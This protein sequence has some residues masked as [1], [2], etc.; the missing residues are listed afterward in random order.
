MIRRVALLLAVLVLG[1]GLA[2]APSHLIS[3]PASS[4]DFVHFES[5]HVHPAVMTPDGTRLLVVSTP[6]NRLSVFDLTGAKPQ[7]IAEIPVGLEPVSVAVRDNGEAWVVNTLSDDISVVDLTTLHVKAT[8]HVGDEPS[9][10]LFAG[11]SGRAFVS[12]TQEDLI[13]I[14]DPTT[15]AEIGAIPVAGRMPRSLAK[16]A[17]GTLVFAAIFNSGNRTTVVQAAEVQD[18]VPDDP[19]FPRDTMNKHGHVLAPVVSHIVQYLDFGVDGAGFYDEYG[20]LWKSKTGYTMPD[21]DVVEIDASTQAVTRNFRGT[22]SVNYN[23]NVLP[24]GRLVTVSTEARNQLRFEP[25][26][27]GYMVDTR[28]SYINTGGVL[29]SRLLN[30][31]INY[32]VTPGPQSEV[33]S[34]M[35]IPTSVAFSASGT[36]AYVTSFSNDKVGIL[37]PNAG[38]NQVLARIPTVAGPSMVVPDEARGVMYIVGR[39]HN[40][41]QTISTDSLVSLDVTR[42][43]FD[44]TPDEIVNGRKFFYG[45]KT[46]GHGDQA[47]ATCHTFGDMDNMVWDLG[48]PFSE[49]IDPP[50]VNPQGLAGFDPQKGP[51]ATQSLRGMLNTEPLHWRGDRTDITAFNHA[52]ISLMGRT[53]QLPDSEMTAFAEFSMPLVYPPNPFRNLDNTLP[54][55][56]DR[57]NPSAGEALFLSGSLVASG[58]NCVDCHNLPAGT[59]RMMV[60]LDTLAV[61]QDLKVPQLRNLYKKTG[62]TDEVGAMTKRGFGY[63]H[64]GGIDKLFRFLGSPRFAFDP[65]TAIGNVARRDVEAF[66]LAFPT[67]MHPAVGVQVTFD[68][69]SNPAGEA[70]VDTMRALV[71]ASQIDLIAKGRVGTQP[72]G[73]QYLGG[74]AWKSDK[75]AE[76]NL[77]TAGL[78]ALAL[79]PSSALTVTGVP[80]GNGLRM[81]I[82]RDRDTYLDGDE[83]DAGSDTGS[84]LST[85]LTVSVNGGPDALRTALERVSPNPS[86]AQAQ[87]RF[88]LA[89]AGHVDLSVYDVLGR[90]VRTLARGRA[91]EAGRWNLSW[92]GRRN[93]GGTAGAGVYF[94][95]M[96]TAQGASTLPIVRIR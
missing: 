91:F 40:E 96:R 92:D 49:Y 43:G 17:A 65:D 6:D 50:V 57:P 8:I 68:G 95:R 21:V 41:L 11:P 18:S 28:I 74:D 13:K 38:A 27:R 7:R 52:F 12:V 29:S 48:D 77:T 35:G 15:R 45:G 20:K 62:Y 46:S 88:A 14:Y 3:S 69:G 79:D 39:F 51:M 34:A 32:S 90:E 42:I 70:R 4:P 25:K 54:S 16:N 93:D 75:S 83:L 67:G 36:R 53:S 81:G 24:D 23:I 55:P 82:D 66:L 58:G 9:D 26:L 63:G 71:D 64:D 22:G 59:N 94:V 33:D 80:G 72:R 85:P 5:S 10:V 86:R 30:P 56:V 84:P 76:T 61:A 37:N 31:H 87:I 73:W 89:R 1:F 44:P 47:C 60:S 78:M 2:I 19:D